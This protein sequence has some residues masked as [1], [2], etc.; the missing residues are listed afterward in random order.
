M[1]FAKRFKIYSLM[2]LLLMAVIVY[3][4]NQP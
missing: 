4:L 1:Q 3:L 2:I